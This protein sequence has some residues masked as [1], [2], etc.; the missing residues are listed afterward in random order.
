MTRPHGLTLVTGATGFLGGRLI[1]R[2]AAE[3]LPVRALIRRD[4]PPH[5][6]DLPLETT[7]GDLLDPPSL[8]AATQGV[9]T[10]IHCAAL[11]TD[12]AP[13]REFQRV[14]GEGTANLVSAAA[15]AGVGRLVHISSTDVYGYVGTPQCEEAPLRSVGLGYNESKILAEKAVLTAG[16]ERGLPY[17]IV[18]PATIYGPRGPFEHEIIPMLQR[19][20]MVLLGDGQQDAGLIYVDNVVDLTLRAASDERALNQTY[21]A[22]DGEGITWRQYCDALAE[23]V[24]APRCNK[25][26]PVWLAYALAVVME[27]G[28]LLLRRSRRPLLTRF[29]VK[30]LGTPQDHPTDKARREL[31]WAPRV[32]FAEGIRRL[33][34]WL[35]TEGH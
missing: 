13:Y 7:R 32:T 1:E 4:L 3:G 2:L 22:C 30:L 18:R 6:T 23:L 16:A 29:S 10:V 15:G 31:G 27:R 11:V 24:G 8:G 25:H 19:E 33:G 17:T 5:L 21:N 34:L 14:N 28:S 35:Q 26:A 9:E 12:Y 20:E